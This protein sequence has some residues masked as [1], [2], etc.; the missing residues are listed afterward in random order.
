MSEK[1]NNFTLLKNC[2]KHPHAVYDFLMENRRLRMNQ[3][4]PYVNSENIKSFEKHEDFLNYLID[5]EYKN[6]FSSDLPDLYYNLVKRIEVLY[7]KDKSLS[8]L[9]LEEAISVYILVLHFKPEKVVETGV[10]DGMSS[11][12]ILSALNENN[13]GNLYSIDFP[14]VGMPRLYGKEPGWIVDDNLRKRWTLVYGKTKK[15]L[16]PLLNEL[17]HVDIFLHDSEHSYTNMKFEFSTVLR[18]M[19]NGSLLLSDDVRSNSAFQELPDVKEFGQNKICLLI[20]KD[21]DLGALIIT[22]AIKN[23][24]ES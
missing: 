5:I 3:K 4:H 11:F 13:K 9:S 19:K 1:A 14:E 10:S 15:K 20:G 12:F 7:G 2:L 6:N 23:T 18:Y 24:V 8:I 21:S 16:A 17:R 22:R